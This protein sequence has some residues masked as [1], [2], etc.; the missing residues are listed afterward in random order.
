MA[1]A[2]LRY[3]IP[4]GTLLAFY[5]DGNGR[6]TIPVCP[7]RLDRAYFL[8]ALGMPVAASWPKRLPAGRPTT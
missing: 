3:R 1:K 8:C 6:D 5:A 4:R 7:Q 2:A